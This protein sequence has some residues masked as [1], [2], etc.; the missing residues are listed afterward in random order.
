MNKKRKKRKEKPQHPRFTYRFN[1]ESFYQWFMCGQSE[2]EYEGGRI[3][4]P[5]I[6]PGRSVG[7]RE[8]L[9][10]SDK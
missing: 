3:A 7:P 2:D 1:N 8:A 10:S 5:K 9:D 6:N 4:S